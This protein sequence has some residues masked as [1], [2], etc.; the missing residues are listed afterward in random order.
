MSKSSERLEG[1]RR[2]SLLQQPSRRLWA[3]EDAECERKS[4]DE[5]RPEL[6]PPGVLADV[7]NDDV[8]LEREGRSGS[9]RGRPG[10]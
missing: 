9:A 6:E 10:G 1:V 7:C 8:L 2:S 3:E 5:G 4:G